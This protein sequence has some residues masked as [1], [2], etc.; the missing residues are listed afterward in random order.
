MLLQLHVSCGLNEAKH[1]I[2]IFL[3]F[4]V[5][6]TDAATNADSCTAWTSVPVVNITCKCV[7]YLM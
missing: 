1:F 2:T 4:A 5:Y 7:L 3:R 6:E